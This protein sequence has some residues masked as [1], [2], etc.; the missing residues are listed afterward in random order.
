MTSK[1]TWAQTHS[2]KNQGV[3]LLAVLWLVAAL[4]VMI[5]GLQHVV[6]GEI[7]IANQLRNTVVHD[8][9]AD[10]AIRLVLQQ[11]AMDQNK[12]AKSTQ[13]R[14]VSVFGSEVTVEIVP[15][16]GFVDLN[17]AP[18]S[19][20]ADTFEYAGGASKEDAQR[21][22]AS[23]VQARDRQGAEG[24]PEK[25]HAVEDLLRLPG[26]DYKVYAKMKPVLTVDI[27]GAGRVNPLAATLETL[28]ILANGDLARAQQIIQSRL[29]NSAS[30]DTTSLAS[31]D[32]ETAPTSY[33]ALRAA[34][35]TPDNTRLVR[36]WRV[37]MA[38]AAYGLP[39]RVLGIDP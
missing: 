4:S 16:N 28:A 13:T 39:W 22:A 7:R 12:S 37:D 1:S 26:M 3:A 18:A 31:T 10:A 21:L 14:T 20:L 9:I 5:G 24:V 38:S 11:L 23:A 33:L 17:N 8:A 35:V 30:M 15:L 25:F 6:R 19:L 36:T 34:S 29:S 27:V 32:M 2:G